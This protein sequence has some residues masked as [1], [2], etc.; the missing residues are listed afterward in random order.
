MEDA[1]KMALDYIETLIQP[2]EKQ[3]QEVLDQFRKKALATYGF[4]L[5]EDQFKKV[6]AS[7]SKKETTAESDNDPVGIR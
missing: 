5:S 6:S 7:F 3:K 1:E 4:L 2:T